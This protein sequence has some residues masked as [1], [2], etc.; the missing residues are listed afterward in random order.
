MHRLRES[1]L[2]IVLRYLKRICSLTFPFLSTWAWLTD[3]INIQRCDTV[4]TIIMFWYWIWSNC[5]YCESTRTLSQ[6]C[7]C[8]SHLWFLNF[9][10][11]LWSNGGWTSNFGLISKS[12][13]VFSWLNLAFHT[14]Q[15]FCF[16]FQMLL[17]EVTKQNCIVVQLQK[18]SLH[19][20][21]EKT[22]SYYE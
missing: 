21:C 15:T 1:F 22:W 2:C 13:K 6:L 7:N 12:W 14:F 4:A 17:E 9:G 10:L 8:V 16:I 19:M 20:H 5:Q 11:K 3:M 18:Q